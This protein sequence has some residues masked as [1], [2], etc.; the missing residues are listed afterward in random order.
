F[1]G[2][3]NTSAA[4]DLT[5]PEGDKHLSSTPICLSYFDTASGKSVLIAELTN[6]TGQL[7]NSSNQILYPSCFTDINVD[8][9][10]LNQVDKLEQLV[11][12]RQQLPAPEEWGLDSAS[13]LLQVI[14]EFF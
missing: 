8:L 7:L 4:I 9:L 12:I 2:N 11:V 13:T 5:L 3:I 1:L 10:Y 6:S 14:S